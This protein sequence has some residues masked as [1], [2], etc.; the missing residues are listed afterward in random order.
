MLLRS[1]VFL[2]DSVSLKP[3]LLD[4]VVLVLGVQPTSCCG[5]V[6]ESGV[7]ELRPGFA[8]PQLHKSSAPRCLD[9]GLP[10]KG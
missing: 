4:H 10:V 5:A 3:W 9:L 1:V 8:G 2:S 7:I 6:M